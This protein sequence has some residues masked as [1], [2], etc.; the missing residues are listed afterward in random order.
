MKNL[1]RMNEANHEDPMLI[2]AVEQ[3][4]EGALLVEDNLRNPVDF[5]RRAMEFMEKATRG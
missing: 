2:Q 1:A 5:V 3:M 4:Y